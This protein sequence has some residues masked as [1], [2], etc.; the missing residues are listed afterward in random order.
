MCRQQVQSFAIP[1][2][3]TPKRCVANAHCVLKHGRKH[4]LKVAGKVADDLQDFR[5]SSLLLQRLV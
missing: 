1:T 4:R 2:V 3:D 5:R